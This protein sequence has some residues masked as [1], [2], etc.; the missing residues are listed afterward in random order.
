MDDY[1]LQLKSGISRPLKNTVSDRRALGHDAR[2][3]INEST[4]INGSQQ[5]EYGGD[6]PY[7]NIW[8]GSITP[9]D[10][11]D[12]RLPEGAGFEERVKAI[13]DNVMTYFDNSCT[14]HKQSTEDYEWI[15]EVY[16]DDNPIRPDGAH[17]IQVKWIPDE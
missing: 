8:E 13:V 16:E 2:N 5:V 9:E 12:E 1:E 10:F 11:P 3:H 6:H 7:I 15:V 4:F 14:P 17:S